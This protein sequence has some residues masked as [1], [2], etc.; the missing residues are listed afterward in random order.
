MHM[1][2]PHNFSYSPQ[3]AAHRPTARVTVRSVMTS[4]SVIVSPPV[5]GPVLIICAVGPPIAIGSSALDTETTGLQATAQVVEL[6][7]LAPDN[8]VL[9]N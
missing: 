1:L 7:L 2:S 3:T 9:V 4:G 8:T 6:A 5:P